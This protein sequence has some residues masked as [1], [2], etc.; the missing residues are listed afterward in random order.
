MPDWARYAVAIQHQISRKLYH[1]VQNRLLLPWSYPWVLY[2]LVQGL[3]AQ[4]LYQHPASSRLRALLPWRLLHPRRHPLT[5]AASWE[6]LL[7]RRH[8]KKCRRDGEGTRSMATTPSR[9]C[10]T[11]Q[12][13]SYPQRTQ[14]FFQKRFLTTAVHSICV[15]RSLSVCRTIA[16]HFSTAR[17]ARLSRGCD[18][19]WSLSNSSPKSAG[20]RKGVSPHY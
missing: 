10:V 18:S 14:S 11:V 16:R 17:R 2:H 6:V 7:R 19:I 13:T 20:K 9:R 8:F 3:S 12:T 5:L 1:L 15:S 4:S